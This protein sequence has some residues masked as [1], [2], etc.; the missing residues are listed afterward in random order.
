MHWGHDS[1]ESKC[2]SV[3]MEL[4]SGGEGKSPGCGG[5]TGMGVV[6]GS[7]QESGVLWTYYSEDM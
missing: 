2:S 7:W 1:E 4:L 3:F 5:D 6:I